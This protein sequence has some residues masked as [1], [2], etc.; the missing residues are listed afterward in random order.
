MD[1]YIVKYMV[2]VAHVLR[3]HLHRKRE[4]EA[5]VSA[6]QPAGTLHL[7]AMLLSLYKVISSSSSGITQHWMC[8]QHIIN[9]RVDQT[10]LGIPLY[11]ITLSEFITISELLE[12]A[13]TFPL[14][15]FF[16]SFP[17]ASVAVSARCPDVLYISF[18]LPKW[19]GI[20]DNY[21]YHVP[22]GFRNTIKI[23][24]E[25]LEKMGFLKSPEIE[26]P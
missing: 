4:R 21:N 26:L 8:I 23:S 10:L 18:P 2:G 7:R 11:H 17:G 9:L 12:A 22:F 25:L 13:D 15:S 3:V 14:R 5:Y 6:V 20:G 19:I 24:S 16:P 1:V